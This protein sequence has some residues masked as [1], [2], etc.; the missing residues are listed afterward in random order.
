[1]NTQSQAIKHV[2]PFLDL[3]TIMDMASL[4][5][6]FQTTI[7]EDIKK[8]KIVCI[9]RDTD[10]CRLCAMF[11]SAKTLI[12]GPGV[13]VTLHHLHVAGNSSLESIIVNAEDMPPRVIKMENLHTC[14]FM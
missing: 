7:N 3:V 11:T 6:Q 12:A 4:N 8:Q 10:I 14:I 9:S 2:L 13:N 1:M 5:K